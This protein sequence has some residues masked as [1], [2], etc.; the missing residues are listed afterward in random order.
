MNATPK[1]YARVAL[2]GALEDAPPYRIRRLAY[3]AILDALAGARRAMDRRDVP[4]KG[5]QLSYA[6]ELLGALMDELDPEASALEAQMHDLYHYLVR[7]IVRANF[8]NDRAAL[9]ECQDLLTPIARAWDKTAM[10]EASPAEAYARG[11]RLE[12]VTA[13]AKRALTDRYQQF[14]PSHS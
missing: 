14:E 12:P 5:S 3:Q 1:L 8:D 7:R 13:A 6:I 2:Q 11:E 4:A 9:N 10:S